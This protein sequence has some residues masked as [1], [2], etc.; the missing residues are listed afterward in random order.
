MAPD[1]QHFSSRPGGD[2]PHLA[3]NLVGMVVVEAL[4]Q[5]IGFGLRSVVQP[6]DGRSHGGAIRS[7]KDQ[8]FPLSRQPQGLDICRVDLEFLKDGC[9]GILESVPVGVDIHLDR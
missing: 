8:C 3:G 7:N 9:N 2:K 6:D 1:P 5:L 4:T